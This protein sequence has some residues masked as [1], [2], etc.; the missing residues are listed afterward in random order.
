MTVSAKR[1][2]RFVL[3]QAPV[4]D[5]VP[6]ALR[7]GHVSRGLHV[8]PRCRDVPGRWCG[9][10]GYSGTLALRVPGAGP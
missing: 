1:L 9:G 6:A 3:A 8:A 10:V 2:E 7:L 4:F 5:Q